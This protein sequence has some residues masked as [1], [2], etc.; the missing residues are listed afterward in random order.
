MIKN[1]KGLTLTEL[2]VTLAILSFAGV[3]IWSVF[4]Q[5]YNY[6]QK[7][8]AKN[9]LQQEGNLII[10]NLTSIH[11]TAR[12][13]K[14]MNNQCEI[15]LEITNMDDTKQNISFSDPN[16]CYQYNS[17][18]SSIIEEPLPSGGKVIN[19]DPFDKDIKLEIIVSEK[20]NSSNSAKIDSMLYRVK[21]GGN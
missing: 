16:L 11:Q 6:S 13:Y 8:S 19:M 17:K 9:R 12:Y 20:K 1:E 10:T 21:A 18:S 4:F 7:A 5:G 3:L 15:H 14:I 2:M